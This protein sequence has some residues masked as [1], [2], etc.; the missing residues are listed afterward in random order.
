M[1]RI[2]HDDG[3]QYGPVSA[4]TLRQWIREGRA[5]AQTR[6]QP[7]GTTGWQT[8]KDLVEFQT[9]LRD[10]NLPPNRTAGNAPL[11]GAPSSRM[12]LV[13]LVL[14][15]LGFLTFGVT[16]LVGLV[17]GIIAMVRIGGSQGRLRG[18]GVAIA[19]MVTSGVALL[20]V[21]II[22]ILA[23]MLLPALAKAQEKAQTISCV[24]NLKQVALATWM[25]ADDNEETFPEA[26]WCDLT[27]G[28]LGTTNVLV[29]PTHAGANCSYAANSNLVGKAQGDVDPGTVMFF[30]SDA[31]WNAVGGE[32]SMIQQPRHGRVFNL[33][34]A[35]GSVQQVQT[36]NL[37]SL[38]W[39]P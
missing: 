9:D 28:Y 34:F 21:P 32:E 31:G 19:G 22:A 1:Y 17:L 38:R 25:Y 37:E 24:N 15:I 2:L 11:P 10:G 3:Q 27:A 7:D 30:E 6:V 20:G 29:C 16:A 18:H 5:H 23:A 35:D 26:V 14:G 8:L 39:E 13:S 12:A 4:D 33:A 36:S